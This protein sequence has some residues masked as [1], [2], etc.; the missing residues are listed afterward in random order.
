MAQQPNT[1]EDALGASLLAA[2][3]KVVVIGERGDRGRTY[4]EPGEELDM[5]K[6]WES[7]HISRNT[8]PGGEPWA[9]PFYGAIGAIGWIPDPNPKP[10]LTGEL[11]DNGPRWRPVFAAVPN[12]Y[13]GQEAD[14]FRD[15]MGAA[16]R[17]SIV[18]AD[19]KKLADQFSRREYYTRKPWMIGQTPNWIEG[20]ELIY[21]YLDELKSIVEQEKDLLGEETKATVRVEVEKR[22][23]ELRDMGANEKQINFALYQDIEGP[24]AQPTPPSPADAPSPA[25]S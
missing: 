6:V 19:L 11:L 18:L 10:S 24:P 22:V 21:M 23:A 12:P 3:F 15:K 14:T 8:N 16:M 20:D 4:G 17:A 5:D 2:G 1:T 9:A 7:S 13:H 25:P